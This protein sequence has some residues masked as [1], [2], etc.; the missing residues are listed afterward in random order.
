MDVVLASWAMVYA[1]QGKY[2]A[3]ARPA[4][5]A[6]EVWRKVRREDWRDI[7]MLTFE[8]GEKLAEDVESALV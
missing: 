4:A 3:A 6:A 1:V 2:G 7:R 8:K 5:A